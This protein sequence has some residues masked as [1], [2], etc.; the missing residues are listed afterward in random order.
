MCWG[1]SPHSLARAMSRPGTAGST[2]LAS[3]AGAGILREKA[4]GPSLT[5]ETQAWQSHT[6][7]QCP[8]LLDWKA[9]GRLGG[10]GVGVGLGRLWLEDI[11]TLG[12]ELGA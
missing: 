5:W 11:M 6:Q 4:G 9:G 3:R 7:G 12:T 10:P 8:A 2:Q 1:R